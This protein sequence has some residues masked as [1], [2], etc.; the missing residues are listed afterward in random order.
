M[1]AVVINFIIA[2]MQSVP[3][4]IAAIQAST[5]MSADEKAKLIAKLQ[6]ELDTVAAAVA[7]VKFQDV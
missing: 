4:A 3:S 7:G 5:S 1:E 2:A 6:G